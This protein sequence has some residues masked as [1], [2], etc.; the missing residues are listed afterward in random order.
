VDVKTEVKPKKNDR[1]FSLAEL[2]LLLA[3]TAITVTL[4]VPMLSSSMRGM[5][6]MG[7]ARSIASTLQLAKLSAI[8]QTTRCRMSFDLGNN[9]WTYERYN[10]AAAQWDT[11]QSVSLCEGGI[12]NN[13][14]AFVAN[15]S[16]AP[17][18]CSTTSSNSIT[19]NSRGIPT[20][21]AAIIYLSNSTTDYAV[22]VS[23]SGKVQ[24][25]KH[26]GSQWISQ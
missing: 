3:L 21:G 22:S 9:N 20:A 12:S 10:L 25:W 23:I 6:L 26:Q 7:Q 24:M 11:Q 19:F 4:S 14:I 2:C 17:S 1:G 15:S 16:T 13:G 8:A 5:Q 18:G